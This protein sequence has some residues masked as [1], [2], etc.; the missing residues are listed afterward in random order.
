MSIKAG[1]EVKLRTVAEVA[2]MCRL[3]EAKIWSLVKTGELRSVKIGWSR[4]IP[5]DAVDQFIR[6]L[7]QEQARAAG[8]AA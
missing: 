1:P 3:S 2:V 6:S 8:G 5:E 4:R 7:E